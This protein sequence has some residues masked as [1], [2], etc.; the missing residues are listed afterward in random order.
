MLD[1]KGEDTEG[2]VPYHHGCCGG[3]FHV[4]GLCAVFIIARGPLRGNSRDDLIALANMKNVLLRF[5]HSI[6]YKRMPHTNQL[7]SVHIQACVGQ[8]QKIFINK[9]PLS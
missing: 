6:S 4:V 8:R 3:A 5:L 7:Y 2:E 9:T 1:K